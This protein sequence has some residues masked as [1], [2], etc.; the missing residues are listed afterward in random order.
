MDDSEAWGDWL[1]DI[2]TKVAEGVV[3]YKVNFPLRVEELKINKLGSAG[4]YTEGKAGAAASTA[5]IP[6]NVL[7]IG[8]AVLMAVL[9]LKA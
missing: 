6:T 1:R 4:Y 7:L 2:G 3:D 9:L 5:G 8:G